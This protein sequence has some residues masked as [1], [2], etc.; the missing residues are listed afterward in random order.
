MTP[1]DPYDLWIN[2]SIL[3]P[4]FMWPIATGFS[5]M[6]HIYGTGAA[7]VYVDVSLPSDWP[8][9]NYTVEL[10][11]DQGAGVCDSFYLDKELWPL[12]QYAPGLNAS[13]LAD[14]AD[15]GTTL[16]FSVNVTNGGNNPDIIDLTGSSDLGWAVSFNVT[17]VTPDIGAVA[18]VTVH[19]STPPNTPPGTRS[20]ITINATS[21][22]ASSARDQ[23][24]LGATVSAQVHALN[25]SAGSASGPL[26]PGGTTRFAVTI[27]NTGNNRDR[28]TLDASA[29]PTGWTFVFENTSMVVDF[30]TTGTV[31]VTVGAPVALTGAI[32]WTPNIT[33]TASDGITNASVLVTASMTLPDFVIS[34]PDI[35]LTNSSPVEGASVTVDC[36]VRNVGEILGLSILVGLTDGVDV[37]TATLA[38]GVSGTAIASFTWVARVGATLLTVTVD[39]ATAVPESNEGNNAASVN[40]HVNKRPVA[41]VAPVTGARAG[42]ALTLSAS[43]STDTDGTVASYSF[44]FGDGTT[45]GWIA[46]AS[47][48]HTYAAAGTFQVVV[49]VRDAQGAESAAAT[50]SVTVSAAP[51][52]APPPPPPPAPAPASDASMLPLLIFVVAVAG[53]AAAAVLLMKRRKAAARQPPPPEA[54]KPPEGGQA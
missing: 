18:N 37:Q 14:E 47:V 51:V 28:F 16:D 22:R 1:P 40:V 32:V 48:N 23:L 17:T 9:G 31:N 54:P 19:V 53:G 39:A 7:F 13:L 8:H 38:M 46:N 50:Q 49:K 30:G 36:T 29:P 15:Q 12:G 2:V 33:V 27:N 25:V 20:N 10:T 3:D 24:T 34:P 26:A 11:L 21:R 41:Q 43:S 6:Y 5:G 42:E 35:L 44:D 52:N 45:T 4:F